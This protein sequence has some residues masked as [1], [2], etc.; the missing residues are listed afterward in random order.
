MDVNGGVWTSSSTPITLT[1]GS[2]DTACVDMEY[3]PGGNGNYVVTGSVSTGQNDT[4]VSNNDY[5]ST[6]LDV[7]D[8]IYARDNVQAGFNGGTYN[9]GN[10]YE[11]GNVFDIFTAQNVFGVQV[12][13]SG[14]TNVGSQIFV[15]LYSFDDQGN[16]VQEDQS[17]YY[18]VQSGDLGVLIDIP[19]LSATSGGYPLNAG[20]SY[21]VVV[22]TDGD[23]GLSNDF[24]VATSGVSQPQTSYY[25]DATD[26][27]WYYSTTTKVVRMNFDPALGTE[28]I[29]NAHNLAVYPNPSVSEAN[30]S[31]YLNNASDVEVTVSDLSGKAVY[32]ESMNNVA[33]GTTEVRVN[34]AVLA[35]GTYL[36]NVKA[37]GAVSTQ[38]L[39]VRK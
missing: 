7:V 26:Q 34:T 20:E 32:V 25:F 18:T 22:G 29:E 16:Y 39:V 31:F 3:T 4:G 36:V 14:F 2:S 37:N 17:D 10:G 9:E 23:G 33:A 19:L 21:V 8:F 5:N 35:G 12:G 15:K 27:T 30:V 1:V 6:E 24:V 11:T 38:K 28:E 13:V